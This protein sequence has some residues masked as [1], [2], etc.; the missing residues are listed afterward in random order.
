MFW[1]SECVYACTCA[2]QCVCNVVCVCVCNVVCMC[3][4]W[5]VCVGGGGGGGACICQHISIQWLCASEGLT[6][7]KMNRKQ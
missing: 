5:S 3:G 2:M 6:D 4:Q 1:G 7:T